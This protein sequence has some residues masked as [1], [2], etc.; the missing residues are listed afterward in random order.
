MPAKPKQVPQSPAVRVEVRV[1]GRVKF[2]QDVY[3]P[4]LTTDDDVL[5]FSAAL[6]PTLVDV[7]PTRP[8]TRFGDDPRDGDTVI[9]QVHSG[10]RK[11]TAAPSPKGAKP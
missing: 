1:G 4:S 2:S 9:Q 7:K 10:S 8:P 11:E 3:D 5:H 6:Q